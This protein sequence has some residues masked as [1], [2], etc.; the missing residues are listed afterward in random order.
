MAGMLDGIFSPAALS[1]AGG[2]RYLQLKRMIEEAVH[3]GAIK[4]GEAL[5]AERE[6]AALT[7]LS[8]VTVRKAVQDLVREGLLV[9]RH[10]SGTFVAP[11]V[12]RVEQSLSNLTSFTEDMASR[13]IAVRS[14]WLDRGIY[15]PSPEEFIALGL[16]SNQ[17]VSRIARLRIGDDE[18]LAIER[19]SLSTSALPDPSA[20]GTSLYAALEKTGMRPV[21]AIQRIS[22]ALLGDKDADLLGV[23]GGLGE[24]QHRAHVVPGDRQGRGIHPIHLS[25]RRLRFRRGTAAVRRRS[26][27]GPLMSAPS[28]TFM[29]REIEEIPAATRRLL[30]ESA[31]ALRAAGD[32]LRERDPAVITTVARGSSDHAATFL[33]YAIEISAGVPVASLGPS[34]AS[35][36]EAEMRLRQAVCISISQSGRSPDIVAMARSA[37]K[38]GAATLALTQ[39]RGLAAL[40]KPRILR[41]TSRPARKRASRRRRASSPRSWRASRSSPAG[42]TTSGWPRRSQRFRIASRRRSPA[43]GPSS[44]AALEGKDSLFIL[45]RGPGIAIANEAAL[46]FKETCGMHAEA[47]SAA[48][49]LH[50][51]V[52]IVRQGFPVIALAVR[53]AA[54]AAVAETVGRVVGQG[55]DVFVTSASRRRCACAALRRHRASADRS[56]GADRLLLRLHRETGAP[57]RRRPRFAALSAQGDGDDLMAPGDLVG[58]AVVGARIFDGTEWHDNKALAR[59]QRR[60]GGGPRAGRLA[61]RR[62]RRGSNWRAGSSCPASSTCR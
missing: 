13:G 41:S 17:R 7:G 10:G 44:I 62:M 22:A 34:L 33:K 59:R 43:T 50:G 47:Y 32:L 28:A 24:P 8:R 40:R 4:P 54:E 42:A 19:A 23:P 61:C 48:E 9:Q 20:V 3:S 45:G 14:V 2:P 56:A 1:G 26:P 37:G 49:V 18:P 38:A 53:D 57:A 52:S 25:R 16:S 15:D 6:I 35:I 12:G 31:D 21:R 60:P 51:P 11:R 5:P 36:Y 27:G 39:R 29:R 55:A 30:G 46:K 58:K